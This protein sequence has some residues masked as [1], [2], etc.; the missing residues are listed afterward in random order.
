MKLKPTSHKQC[1]LLFMVTVFR[2]TAQ[3]DIVRALEK[4][5]HSLQAS[6]CAKGLAKSPSNVASFCIPKKEHSYS[7]LYNLHSR[8]GMQV[9]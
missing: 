8:I 4:M 2:L 1:L 7:Y 3:V 9:G 6:K 5:I